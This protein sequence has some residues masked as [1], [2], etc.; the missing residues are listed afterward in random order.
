[1]ASGN[2]YLGEMAGD[3]V[4]MATGGLNTQFPNTFWLFG[5]FVSPKAR[6]TGVATSLVNA[7]EKWAKDQGGTELYLHVTESM[8]RARSFYTKIGFSLNG[9]SVTMDRDT[10]I[11]LVTMVKKLD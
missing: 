9:G 11:K 2:C 6:G 5:M 7:V 10:S 1:M 4:G 8:Q 3:V